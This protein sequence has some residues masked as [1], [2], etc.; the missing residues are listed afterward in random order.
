MGKSLLCYNWTFGADI[1]ILTKVLLRCMAQESSAFQISSGGKY[2]F[3][4][5]IGHTVQPTCKLNST[6]QLTYP[7]KAQINIVSL[8]L[9]KREEYSYFLSNKSFTVAKVVPVPY[10]QNCHPCRN[11][12]R[13]QTCDHLP[14]IEQPCG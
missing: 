5:C 11:K 10:V 4:N 6:P 14:C 1:I 12:I 7:P 13:M 2:R 9:S 3:Y 8:S